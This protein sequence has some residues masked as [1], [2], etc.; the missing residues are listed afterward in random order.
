MMAAMFNRVDILELLS[1]H[2]ARRDAVDSRGMTAVSLADS[3]GAQDAAAWL[4]KTQAT[5]AELPR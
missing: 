4:A 2:G 1:E 5:P 3:M